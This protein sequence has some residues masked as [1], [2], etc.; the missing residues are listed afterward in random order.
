M[1]TSNRPRDQLRHYQQTGDT[2]QSHH[3]SAW[4]R[5][6]RS[7]LSNIMFA[8]AFTRRLGN[9]SRMFVNCANSV[10]DSTEGTRP[11]NGGGVLDGLKEWLIERSPFRPRESLTPLYLAISPEVENKMITGRH[12]GPISTEL[13]PSNYARD[14]KLHDELWACSENL[15]NEKLKT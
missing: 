7:K 2:P 10:Y 9:E 15:T 8:K 13:G 12:F 3:Q 4:D 5:F 6:Y 1:A 14:E 11:V